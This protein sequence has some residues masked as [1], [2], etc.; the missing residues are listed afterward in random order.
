[1][2]RNRTR[3]ILVFCIGGLAGGALL[4]VV[5]AFE[6]TELTLQERSLIVGGMLSV[7]VGLYLTTE[8]SYT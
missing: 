2:D 7:F 8:K 4:P 6:V 3:L 1:M 5:P